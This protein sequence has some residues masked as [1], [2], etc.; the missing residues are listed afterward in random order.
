M[1]LWLKLK[2]SMQFHAASTVSEGN[3]CYTYSELICKAERL[4]SKLDGICYAIY[5]R[6]ELNTAVAILACLAAQKTAV[7]L[8]YRYGEIHCQRILGAIQPPYI[9]SDD[10]ITGNEADC[11]VKK[12]GYHEYQVPEINPAL[13]MCTSGTTGSPK[14]A[15]LTDNNILCNLNDIRSYFSI[16]PDD[17]VF[18]SRPLYHCAVLTGEFL[19]SLITGCNL[20]FYSESFNPA[21]MLRVLKEKCVT[22]WG[23]T[24]TLWK[25]ICL[26]AHS[27]KYPLHLRV[28]MVSGESLSQRT[29]DLLRQT[30][31]QTQ[32]YHV[33]G[34]T[35][36]SPRVTYLPPHEFDEFFESVGYPLDS[37]EYRIVDEAGASVTVGQTGVLQIK[38][39]NVMQGYYNDVEA[40]NRVVINGWLDTGDMASVDSLGHLRIHGRKD[41]M[42]IRAGMNIYPAEVEHALSSDPRVQDVYV[43]GKPDAMYGEA[44]VLVISGEF[45]SERDIRLLC[46]RTLP[47]YEQPTYIRWLDHLTYTASGKIVRLEEV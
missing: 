6:S 34:L 10:D 21:I 4:A 1:N 33:Y 26:L 28:A 41:K 32:I 17:C 47:S 37:V 7:P 27:M 39:G 23:N 45:E 12:S 44:I 25:S 3:R 35:E 30:F 22:V 24:P 13:I 31:P 2:E 38:G 19:V 46:A 18:L 11:C 9:I 40:T 16:R 8:S 36:A 15:M 14:G 42:I 29:A 5:C 20:V 43:Y